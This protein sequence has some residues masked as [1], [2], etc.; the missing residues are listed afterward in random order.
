MKLCLFFML[1]FIVCASANVKAQ[2]EKVSLNLS[3]VTLKELFHEIQKQTQLSFVYNMEQTREV[4]TFTV[5]AESESV[6]QVLKRLFSRTG[7]TFEFTENLIILHPKPQVPQEN[8]RTVS[9]TVKDE[10]G[11]PLPGVTI[12]LK[13]TPIGLVTDREGK[14]T[15]SYPLGMDAVLSF[16]FI[17]MK[18]QEVKVGEKESI[19][20]VMYEDIYQL[21][22]AVI[23]STGYYSIPKER[24]TGSFDKI[25]NKTFNYTPGADILTRLEGV[26]TDILFNNKQGTDQGHFLS[27]MTIRGPS[28][29]ET[30][31]GRSPLIVLNNMIYDGA[32]NDINPNDVESITILKDAAATSIWG[33]NAGNGVIVITTKKGNYNR[34]MQISASASF[35]VTEKPR[36]NYYPFLKS[37]DFIDLEKKLFDLGMYDGD[38]SANWYAPPMIS[39][40]VE[41]LAKQRQGTLSASEAESRINATRDDSFYDQLLKYIY[42]PQVEQ[43]YAL[44]VNG[45]GDNINYMLSLGYDQQKREIKY[46]DNHRVSLNSVVSFKPVQKLEVSTMIMLAFSTVNYDNRILTASSVPGGSRSSYYPYAR[47]ADDQ[48]NPVALAKTSN[49][50]WMREA[51]ELRGLDWTYYPLKDMGTTESKRASSNV[52]LNT[53]VSYQLSPVFNAAVSYQYNK[54]D[55]NHSEL[56]KAEAYSIREVINTYTNINLDASDPLYRPI[57]LGGRLQTSNSY[58]VAHIVRGQLNAE[59]TWGDKHQLSAIAGVEVQDQNTRSIAPL[60]TYG[61]DEKILSSIRVD[62]ANR[63]PYQMDP[64]SSYVSTSMLPGNTSFSDRTFRS[65]SI[66]TNIGYTYDRRY[67]FTFSARK[68]A[69][70]MFGVDRNQRGNPLWSAGVAWTISNEAFYRLDWLPYLKYRMTYGCS[71]NIARDQSAYL[72]SQFRG[73]DYQSGEPYAIITKPP[74]PNLGWEQVR[75]FNMGIDFAFINN[76]LFGSMEYYRKISDEI[77]AMAP[78]DPTTGLSNLT[79]NS[80]AFKGTG[81]DVSLHIRPVETSHFRWNTDIQFTY[82]KNTTTKYKYTYYKDNPANLIAGSGLEGNLGYIEGYDAYPVFSFKFAGLDSENGNPQG[83]DHEGNICTTYSYNSPMLQPTD[84]EQLNYHGS[85]MPRTYGSF[86]NTVGWKGVE[87]SFNIT[88]KLNYYFRKNTVQYGGITSWSVNSDYLDRWKAPGD[89]QYTTVPSMPETLAGLTDYNLSYR[90]S[91][92]GRSSANVAKGDHIRFNDIML[93]YTLPQMKWGIKNIRVHANLTNVGILWRANKWDIDPDLGT[94]ATPA[95]KIFTLGISAHF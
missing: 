18:A 19:H 79:T 31:K 43:Q 75:Q 12:I 48:G 69:S 38:L 41:V 52:L 60:P 90:D 54:T 47:L 71:G 46:T 66:Y 14:F 23:V 59:K 16:S 3:H 27:N 45:G 2:Q 77:F 28:T 86:R 21:E 4:G 15:I 37:S 72:T 95:P 29:R 74:N 70:N 73:V 25:D 6:E 30:G 7:I 39:P 34:P 57:P 24:A 5:K 88:Y 40:V 50:E 49:I 81:V 87:L 10:A 85:G 92:Y 44:N 62:F 13:N 22:E 67:I 17:G 51:G 9:G 65:T 63:Y 82:N 80:A 35:R 32:I 20:V 84:V 53:Q 8:K 36:L 61:Y 89:E 33:I 56:E 93:A 94:Y 78:V 76:R 91:F 64:S 1:G 68:D 42:R 11:K 26:T 58:Y 55:E 83:Y